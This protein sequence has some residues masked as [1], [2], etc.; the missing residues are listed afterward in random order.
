VS[1]SI[2][3]TIFRIMLREYIGGSGEGEWFKRRVRAF[4]GCSLNVI[5]FLWLRIAK[6]VSDA[7]GERK[8][9]IW[10]L[11]FL[12][13]Y[14][15]EMV[16]ARRYR[17]SEKTLRRYVH[18]YVHYLSRIQ[19]VDFDYR[20]QHW[21]H[22]KPSFSLDGTD[23]SVPEQRPLAPSDFSHKIKHSALRYEVGLSLGENPR[24]VWVA[25][26]VPAGAWSDLTLARDKIVNKIDRDEYVLADCGYQDARY[27][28]LPRSSQDP[29]SL[30]FNRRHKAIMARHEHVNNRLKMFSCLKNPFRHDRAFHRL[31]VF[32]IANIVNSSLIEN[33]QC[34]APMP[35][36]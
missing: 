19:M 31:C 1:L 24:I 34:F 16:L 17:T 33:P 23:F 8:H 3:A 10:A 2:E 25:G 11:D 30:E 28:M 14:D 22:K 4:Y 20:F 26:G 29:Q 9:L 6:V 27:F 7:Q 18:F 15:T 21:P 5:V 13:T 35:S 12:K 32:A 36:F